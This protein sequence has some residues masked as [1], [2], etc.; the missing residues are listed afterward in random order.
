MSAVLRVLC[1]SIVSDLTLYSSLMTW[2]MPSSSSSSSSS[3]TGCQLL[4][5]RVPVPSN[6][7]SNACMHGPVLL[8]HPTLLSC[9]VSRSS[10]IVLYAVLIAELAGERERDASGDGQGV[11]LSD[12]FT[13]RQRRHS[14]TGISQKSTSNPHTHTMP[15][16]RRR[17]RAAA[18]AADAA[19]TTA[20]PGRGGNNANDSDDECVIQRT[21]DMAIHDRRDV[22]N[23]LAYSSGPT[24]NIVE[25][26][27][28][29][30][31]RIRIPSHM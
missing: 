6:P 15:P 13:L 12:P 1:C 25:V 8:C 31:W 11:S 29:V 20:A 5:L 17:A 22:T 30:R 27:L 3:C 19:Q 16:T 10:A 2:V 9:A 28:K 24:F 21:N 14:S 23:I 18:A 7:G 26:A 4:I